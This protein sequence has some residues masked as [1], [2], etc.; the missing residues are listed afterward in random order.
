M[1]KFKVKT[2]TKVYDEHEV[3]ADSF[4]D[5]R[6]LVLRAWMNTDSNES[7][8]TYFDI[9]EIKESTNE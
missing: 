2:L 4:G 1:K 9:L 6:S 3:T 7:E 8:K 5:A